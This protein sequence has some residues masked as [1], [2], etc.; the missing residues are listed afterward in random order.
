MFW[1]KSILLSSQYEILLT[2][3]LI[4]ILATCGVC[5][6]YE[7][8]INIKNKVMLTHQRATN[9]QSVGVLDIDSYAV[10]I[11]ALTVKILTWV[12][13]K[14]VSLVLRTQ[15]KSQY[16][17]RSEIVIGTIREFFNAISEAQVS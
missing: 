2:L 12:P 15:L 11:L 17:K 9:D 13:V 16:R 1:I 10:T 4:R 3:D 7:L 14:V 5:D 6:T 8:F